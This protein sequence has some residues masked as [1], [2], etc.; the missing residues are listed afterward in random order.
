M[1]P[2]QYGFHRSFNAFS[3][4]FYLLISFAS[5]IVIIYVIPSFSL[6]QYTIRI[7]FVHRRYGPILFR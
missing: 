2:S 5:F 6:L 1:Y 4:A 3:N 7:F